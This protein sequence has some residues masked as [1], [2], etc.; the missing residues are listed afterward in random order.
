MS[1]YSKF[2]FSEDEMRVELHDKL[3]LTS[4]EVS[5]NNLP[6]GGGVPFFHSHKQNEEIYIILSGKGTAELD[7]DTFDISAGDCLRVDPAASRKISPAADSP[8]RYICIQAKAGSLEA[9]TMEDAE[10]KQ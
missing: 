5:I 4:A 7:G 8:M 6:A 2:S 10:I 3:N 9:F 1:N